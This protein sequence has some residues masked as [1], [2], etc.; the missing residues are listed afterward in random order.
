M[1]WKIF[2][3]RETGRV[4]LWRGGVSVK[5]LEWAEARNTSQE[6]LT[7]M[8]RILAEE[9]IQFRDVPGLE[10][11]LDLPP[12]ATARRIAETFQNTYTTFVEETL[13]KASETDA[14]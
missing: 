3:N 8:Q 10:L 9:G 13:S 7:A 11:E 1:H 14:S 12:S 2:L 6:I 5:S 4:E